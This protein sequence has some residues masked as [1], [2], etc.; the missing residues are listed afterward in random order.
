MVMLNQGFKL[1]EGGQDTGKVRGGGQEMG[2][3]WS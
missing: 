2:S 3:R 1:A